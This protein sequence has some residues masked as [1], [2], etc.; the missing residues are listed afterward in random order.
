[1]DSVR[2]AQYALT[3]QQ[4]ARFYEPKREE[5]ERLKLLNSLKIRLQSVIHQLQLSLKENKR[6]SKAK[7]SSEIQKMCRVSIQSIEKDLEATQKTMMDIITKDKILNHLF[8]IITSV[9]N[10]GTVTAIEIILA[11]NEFKNFDSP[12]KFA[13]YCGVAPFEHSSGTSVKGKTRVSH[14]ANKRVKTILHMAAVSSLHSK[15]EL[16][17]YYERKV[18]EGH[19]KMSVI[20]AIR[21]KLIRRIFACVK[22][23]RLYEKRVVNRTNKNENRLL[24]VS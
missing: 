5:L 6:F 4:K 14:L 20:N 19:N 18:A 15:G 12:S 10:I 16:R 11:T 22:E 24:A 8:K 9:E 1:V 23:D 7:V 13:C 3:N 2:I 21:N 17:V